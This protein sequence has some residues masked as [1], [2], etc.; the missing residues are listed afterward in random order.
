MFKVYDFEV[1]PNDWMCVILN[2]ANNRIIRIHND[3]ERLQS[4]L[5]SKD[6]LVGFNNY[7]YDDIILWAILT[8]QDP[9]EISQQIIGGS[10]KRKVNCGFLT[11]DVK[12]ELINK[13]LSLKEVMANL[14]MNIIETPVDFNQEELTSEEVQTILDYC[15]NDVKATGEAFQKR[16]DYFASKFE[17]IESFKLHPSD[18]KKTR[19]NLAST[20]LKAFKMKDHKRDRLKLS[21]DKRLKIDELP[22]LVVDFYN[23]IHMSYL[24]GGAV[25]DL[26]KRQF[27]YKIAGLTH[28]YGFG[29]LHAAKENY[30]GEG[31]FL[32]IDAKSYFPTLKINNGF[33]SRA[34]KMPERYE[35]IYQDRLSYQAA[36]ESKEEIYK[37]LLNAAVGACK[38]EFNAL[39]DP[40]QFNNIVV[41]GQLILTHLIVLL[42]PFIELIQSNTDG[43]IVKYEDKSFRPFIDEIIE[44]FS[45]HYEIHFKVNEINKIAQ[46]DANNYCVRYS[47]GEIVAKGIMKNFEGGT[48]ER[49]SLSIIDTALVN[50]YM[51]DIPIQKTV[52]NMFKKDLSA[53]Q[54]VAKQGKFEGMTC[55]AF[56][57]G[58]MQMIE[59][60]K[61]NR[62]FATTDPKRGGVYK[63]RDEKYQKVS[64]SPE[65]AIVWNGPLDQFEK[66]KIDLNWYVKMIQKQLFV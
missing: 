59:L 27:E 31:Y 1:F 39:F 48:W 54:L 17:I 16:E 30:L 21:Y 19:A 11:L 51:H 49:N 37:I 38:S 14:G 53:F 50:Y 13:S 7:H 33:I 2:L 58:K 52:I 66:R 28:T 61:V 63:V 22:K 20:V 9:Y 41:N 29:G 15:E 42:E 65:Q 57:D 40:Q 35:K 64:N 60:Q 46:R 36:G 12:Q 32:H 18:V 6:I 34:A 8:D 24:E 25:T 26:E 10:F 55:E 3:K 56:E 23:N 5:S 62:I 43:L 44:R 45:K 4:A 47:D